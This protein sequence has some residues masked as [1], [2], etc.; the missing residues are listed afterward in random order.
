MTRCQRDELYPTGD[1]QRMGADEEREERIHPFV[2]KC[3]KSLIDVA[4]RPGG[5]DFDL[6]ADYRSRRLQFW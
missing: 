6:P 3:R 5:D 1:E 4:I 2:Q